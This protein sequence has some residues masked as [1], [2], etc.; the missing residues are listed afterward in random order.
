M[1]RFRKGDVLMPQED[2]NGFEKVT[3]LDLQR[4]FYHLKI[5]NGTETVREDVV[6]DN[7]CLYKEGTKRRKR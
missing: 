6:D 5:M 3:V 2:C 7:Y 4:G 1:A